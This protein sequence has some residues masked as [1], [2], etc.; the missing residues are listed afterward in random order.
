MI[1]KWFLLLGGVVLLFLLT[2][3]AGPSRLEADYGNSS[4]LL[5]VNQIYDPEAEKNTEPV[6]GLDG[7]A[8]QA[9]TEKYRKDFEKPSPPAPSPLT[10]GNSSSGTK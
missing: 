7:K 9:S 6:V 2:S 5:K 8:A 3:C 4:K 1:R 10:M